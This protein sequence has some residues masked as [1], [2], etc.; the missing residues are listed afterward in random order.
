VVLKKI[1]MKM[2]L[3]Y[4]L[5][6]LAMAADRD[7]LKTR[8]EHVLLEGQS[9]RIELEE[10]YRAVDTFDDYVAAYYRE[11]GCYVQ[12]LLLDFEGDDLT[13]LLKTYGRI[14]SDSQSSRYYVNKPMIAYDRSL[15]VSAAPMVSQYRKNGEWRE[16]TVLF[17]RINQ[18]QVLMVEFSYPQD[19]RKSMI[20]EIVAL[21]NSII[22]IEI[23]HG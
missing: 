11:G 18:R 15:N 4:L 21:I 8:N 7:S 2:L 22:P 9:F 6:V 5:P 16:E 13:P 3:I 23:S 1:T 17:R 14:V 20:K 10:G 12:L 19:T